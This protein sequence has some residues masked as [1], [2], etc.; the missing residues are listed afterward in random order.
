MRNVTVSIPTDFC[1]TEKTAWLRT[2]KQTMPREGEQAIQEDPLV[3]APLVV[4]P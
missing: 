1:I 2:H 4:Y 3:K